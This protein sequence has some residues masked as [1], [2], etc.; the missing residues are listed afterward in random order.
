MNSFNS[1]VQNLNSIIYYPPPS[2]TYTV[3]T[4]N[5]YVSIS[6]ITTN[7]LINNY[8][9]VVN[10]ISS[11]NNVVYTNNTITL[12]LSNP[13]TIPNLNWYCP[14][15]V[16]LSVIYTGGAT[17]SVSNTIITNPIIP[18]SI[19]IINNLDIS[20]S[21]T[22]KV[23]VTVNFPYTSVKRYLNGTYTVSSNSS[24]EGSG[25]G[26]WVPF[27]VYNSDI[28]GVKSSIFWTSATTFP[29]NSSPTGTGFSSTISG[30]A[31]NPYYGTWL[32]IKFPF[33]FICKQIIFKGR[34][35]GYTYTMP[36]NF[37]FTGSNDGSTFYQILNVTNNSTDPYTGTLT[38]NTTAYNY[39]RITIN[40]FSGS[41]NN[42]SITYLWIYS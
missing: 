24:N 19:K 5:I 2:F 23:N 3:D 13:Y 17:K 28:T 25:N 7:I 6:S 30:Y 41:D 14:Y 16:K 27:Q 37:I 38:T 33:V 18:T 26:S 22:N 1:I 15:T 4:A 42:P 32:Q 34:N 11:G 29:S 36:K 39:Y 35:D 21:S 12:P 9:L 10:D 31:S 8:S 40:T 20:F